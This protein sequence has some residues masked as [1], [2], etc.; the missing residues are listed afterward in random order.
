MQSVK[1]RVD[2]GHGVYGQRR[3]ECSPDAL[4]DELEQE[5]PDAAGRGFAL[6][7]RIERL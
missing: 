5:A 6:W 3:S 7:E 2:A 1:R 4:L